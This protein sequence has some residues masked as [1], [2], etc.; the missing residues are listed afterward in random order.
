MEGP[1]TR[2]GHVGGWDAGCLAGWPIRLLPS[3]R[4][5]KNCLPS[6]PT[7][8]LPPL[9]LG[10]FK[11]CT[12][13]GLPLLG[14]VSL[15]PRGLTNREEHAQTFSLEKTSHRSVEDSTQPPCHY[16]PWDGVGRALGTLAHCTAFPTPAT[17]WHCHLPL[18]HSLFSHPCL[19][20]NMRPLSVPMSGGSGE[21][22]FSICPHPQTLMAV[23]PRP[24]IKQTSIAFPCW[25]LMPPCLPSLGGSL[26]QALP[27]K[28]LGCCA[29][30]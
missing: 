3:S 19:H 15:R 25:Q 23:W 8:N 9:G 20:F 1:G 14:T 18:L 4:R 24:L 6:L 10:L 16:L 27:P 12:G 28:H 21:A 2:T 22:C 11:F 29:L 26:S 7:M 30:Q 5:R 13:M 17:A